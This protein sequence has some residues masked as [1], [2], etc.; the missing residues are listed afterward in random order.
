G[1]HIALLPG[2]G[3]AVD[4]PD[5]VHAHAETDVNLAEAL[6]LR[7]LLQAHGEM[8]FMPRSTDRDFLTPADSSLRADLNER[9][10]LA[11]QF[12]PDLFVSIHHNADPGGAH[13]RN[14]TQTYYKLGDDGSSLDAAA[15][16][17]RYLR[18]NLSIEAQRIL[19][20]N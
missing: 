6:E 3:A 14:E 4:G 18:R 19:A 5:G 8:V 10:R 1:R 7:N 13:D 9:V 12:Q 20:G 17:H 16:I 15:S 2:H 11:N